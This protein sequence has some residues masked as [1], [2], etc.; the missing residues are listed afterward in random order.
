MNY[1][2]LTD[3]EIRR[4]ES[5]RCSADDWSNVLV[6]DA[7]D[8][9]FVS[10]TAFSGDVRL[11]SFSKSFHLEGGF[12]RHS[13][14]C[15]ATLH[16][17]SVGDDS[18]IGNVGRFIVNYD[19]GSNVYIDS[20]GSI[21][22]DGMSS[23][24]NG[25]SVSVLNEAGGRDVPIYDRLSAHLA[26]MM[27]MYRYRPKM[28]EAVTAM[29]SDYAEKHTGN[30]GCIGDFARIIGAGSITDVN[31]GCYACIN[32]AARLENGTLASSQTD[33]VL[34]GTDVIAQDFIACAG[35][36]VTDGAVMVHTFVGQGTS[37]SHL[38]S[39]HDSLFFSNCAC[40]NGEAAAI[41]A[42]PYTVSMH[43]SSLLIAGMFSFIN[44]GSGSNQSNHMYKLGPIHQGVVERGSKTTSDSYI[45]WPAKIGAFSLVM[46][47]HV[48]HPDTSRLPFS[49][50]IEN[51]GKSYLVP[52]VNLKS[53]G[54]IR[55]TQ[56]W[57]RR[58]KRRDPDRLDKINFNLLSP[59]TVGK[60]WDAINLLEQLE[61]TS[62][63]T[64]DRYTYQ[65]MVI[66]P[67]ALRRGKDYYHKAIN[68]F[69]GNSLISRL[70]NFDFSDGDDS[71]RKWLSPSCKSGSGDWLDV[72]GMIAPKDDIT[73][74]IARI[75]N[76]EVNSLDEI[77]QFFKDEDSRYYDME[78]TWVST[79]FSQ[80]FG[81]PIE[82]ITKQD[83][84]DI[85]ELWKDSVVAIDN[86]LY[87]DARKEFSMQAKTGFGVD[88]SEGRQDS[89]FAQVR[90]E[91]DKDPFVRMVVDHI[92]RKAALGND[93][94][95][96]V[97]ASIA[98]SAHLA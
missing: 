57:P 79:H 1:R 92:S 17:V 86:L 10:D 54:T 97:K 38:F 15:R 56:K 6:A 94:I 13:G 82:E 87:E 11:G 85:I 20:V 50:L 51:K 21:V 72:C 25:V 24:G 84:I 67:R 77:E 47:R 18:F 36:K 39:A 88:G 34:I 61:R 3:G 91:F 90:G 65:S 68:K 35:A 70:R 49:Y 48:A 73:S 95:A 7:F 96:K 14:I 98:R 42:G 9:A 64:A 62:G 80:W 44:A 22:C 16:N 2:K 66:E 28:I 26:Y 8:A 76:G 89:D 59:Y 93:L 81:K 74:F 78:W 75:E 58:D 12:T 5:N 52:G 69:M 71:L 60:M 41:F 37:L 45:L 55:D 19:I 27:A 29:I 40:E 31:V 53:V 43:K 33:P 63:L 83:V 30:R 46:G 23:F 4:L 32:G